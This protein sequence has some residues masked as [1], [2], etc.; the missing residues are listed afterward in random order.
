MREIKFRVW[1]EV[2]QCYYK[3]TIESTVT[4][5]GIY[6][7]NFGT[8]FLPEYISSQRDIDGKIICVGDIVKRW[9]TILGQSFD[10]E[11]TFVDDCVCIRVRDIS[12]G[13]WYDQMLSIYT[14]DSDYSIRVIG[15]IHEI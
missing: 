14:K 13:K 12:T 6:S 15:N 9:S 5:S 4:K 10:N 7:F 11:I 8:R 1:D 3:S 2:L